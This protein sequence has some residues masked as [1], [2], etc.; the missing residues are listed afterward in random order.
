MVWLSLTW[1]QNWRLPALHY[2][3]RPKIP[4]VSWQVFAAGKS[5][6]NAATATVPVLVLQ[7]VDH[8]VD[9]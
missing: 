1:I 3:V 5:S 2:A 7:P 6:S 9:D 8:G 4:T